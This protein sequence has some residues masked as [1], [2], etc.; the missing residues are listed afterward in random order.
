MVTSMADE[1]ATNDVTIE[2]NS[3]QS[4]GLDAQRAAGTPG[5]PAASRAG[6]DMQTDIA[7]ILASV[8]LPERH[9]FRAG[10]D[11]K[12][13]PPTPT[14]EPVAAAQT[15]APTPPSETP[16]PTP[17]VSNENQLV[18][19]HTL[20]DDI[21]H[22][23][24]DEKMSLVRAASLEQDRK[25][26]DEGAARVETA[27]ASQRRNRIFGV[28]FISALLVVIGVAAILGVLAVLPTPSPA[29]QGVSDS[30]VF[31]E[32]SLQL[33]LESM[34]PAALKGQ[35]A[36]ARESSGGSLGSITRIIPTVSTTSADGTESVR[37]ATTEEFLR[38]LGAHPSDELLR[39][40]GDTFFFGLHAVDKN[41]PVFVVSVNSYEHAF[42]GML[43][44]EKDMN[45]DLAP[46]YTAVSAYRVDTHGIPQERVFTDEIM[47]NYDTRILTDDQGAVQLYYSFP[48]TNILIIAESPYSFPEVLSRL[49]A[50][51]HL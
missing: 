28:L 8:G 10:A 12:G 13:P 3:T 16:A 46:A 42:A 49:R 50:S 34:S 24:R 41:A 39:A 2:S 1:N 21:Q 47:R 36:G 37:A 22:V 38:A 44:W 30:L 6:H 19:V 11:T 48:N 31:A 29:D 33:P 15:T 51:R 43:A 14:P 5:V 4:V 35:I 17:P 40:L 20:K 27:G 18:A 7:S 26:R 45:T 9:E 25:L 23:V 32:Q